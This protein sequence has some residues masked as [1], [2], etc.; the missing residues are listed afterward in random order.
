MSYQY[1]SVWSNP[2]A[3][4]SQLTSSTCY[5]NYW[6]KPSSGY[7]LCCRR[8]G[9]SPVALA[10]SILM[11]RATSGRASHH[12]DFGHAT[13][14]RRMAALT[15]ATILSAMPFARG[16]YV[17]T[18][19]TVIPMLLQYLRTSPLNSLPLSTLSRMGTPYQQTIHS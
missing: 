16:F 13:M 2:S 10:G 19:V 12:R 4:C 5:H 18:Y 3:T 17:A 1:F 8:K 15:V 6:V 11:P 9:L 7:C 14:Q